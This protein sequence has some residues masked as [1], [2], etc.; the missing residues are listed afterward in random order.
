MSLGV[1]LQKGHR[2][3]ANIDDIAHLGEQGVHHAD[4]ASRDVET[5]CFKRLAESGRVQPAE[6]NGITLMQ[7]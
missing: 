5:P 6:P 4:L 7:V 2:T 1:E 3:A